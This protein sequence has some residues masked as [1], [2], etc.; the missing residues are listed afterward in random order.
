MW[1]DGMFLLW[2]HVSN[3]YHEDS[4]CGLQ[5][6]PKLRSD[7]INLTPYSIMNVRLAAQILSETVGKILLQY[8]P[9]DAAGT[10]KYC[11]MMDTFFDC[12]NVRNSKEGQRKSIKIKMMKG[13]IGYK[14][15]F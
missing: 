14:M 7:H 2:S 3:L 9:P 13:S 4:E 12:C 1:N 10:A 11:L 8:G 5:Y 15:S 6:L